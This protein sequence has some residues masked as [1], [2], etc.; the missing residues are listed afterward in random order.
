M[1]LFSSVFYLTIGLCV[2]MG[3]SDMGVS[4]VHSIGINDTA[5]LSYVDVNDLHLVAHFIVRGQRYAMCLC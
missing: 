2:A 3:D 1:V 5:F 4:Y